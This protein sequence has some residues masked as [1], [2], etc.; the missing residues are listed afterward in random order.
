MSVKE[1]KMPSDRSIRSA[2]TTLKKAGIFNLENH[3]V[4]MELADVVTII[5]IP[6]RLLSHKKSTK[7]RLPKTKKVSNGT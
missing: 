6:T 1:Q 5:T 7:K 3:Q 4:N 2:L